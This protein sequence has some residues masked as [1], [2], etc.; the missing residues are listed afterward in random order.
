M[1]AGI[2]HWHLVMFGLLA[3]TAAARAQ[4]QASPP[5]AGPVQPAPTQSADVPRAVFIKTMDAEFRRRDGNGDGTL[6]ASE[7]QQF[8]AREALAAAR[9]ANRD[10]FT[11]LDRDG[12]GALSPDEFVALVGPVPPPNIS[13]QML[14][15]DSNR[16]Q[17]V[18]I[19]EY[20]AATLAAFDRL[21]T[22]LDGVVTAA[23][24]QA[25]KVASVPTG[26]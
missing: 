14:R 22:D 8:E 9:L 2:H 25:G 19:V 23:E 12:N 15:L 17:K 18:S 4:Q 6:V 3:T 21:D 11:R 16:D 13:V 24:M 5:Q 7:L 26:R 1:V 10:L 20:R